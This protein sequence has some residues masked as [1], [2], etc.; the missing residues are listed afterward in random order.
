MSVVAI[1]E[2][3]EEG[4]EESDRRWEGNDIY[5]GFPLSTR[6]RRP[7]PNSDITTLLLCDLHCPRCCC[8][9]R[10][11]RRMSPFRRSAHATC[12]APTSA[13]SLLRKAVS[14]T[15]SS[16]RRYV[17]DNELGGVQ[18]PRAPAATPS[19]LLIGSLTSSL[20]ETTPA[21]AP[22][23]P[24]CA[25]SAHRAVGRRDQARLSRAPRPPRH[26]PR[27]L[28]PRTLLLPPRHLPRRHQRQARLLSRL[29]PV[30]RIRKGAPL[31]IRLDKQRITGKVPRASPHPPVPPRYPP[32]LRHLHP[33]SAHRDSR[34]RAMR[35][36]GLALHPR[37]RTK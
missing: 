35:S 19:T 21:S 28:L 8:C 2:D 5:P 18:S 31:R 20:Q 10:Y 32:L 29:P 13:A 33:S 27:A 3:D 25:Q 4:E 23:H 7:P 12:A 9:S 15:F 24:P 1:V 26:H 14:R 16:I 6:R 37:K 30:E 34:A 22:R 17:L 36:L 11:A